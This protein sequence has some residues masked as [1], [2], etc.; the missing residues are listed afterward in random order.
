ML[1]RAQA[2]NQKLLQ[3][4]AVT[5]YTQG[6]RLIL[7]TL[8]TPG[9][10]IPQVDPAA[11]AR[12]MG[13]V[14]TTVP[15]SAAEYHNAIVSPREQDFIAELLNE[16]GGESSQQ[17]TLY[18]ITKAKVQLCFHRPDLGVK[19]LQLA[20]IHQ[21]AGQPELITFLLVQSL[22]YLALIRVQTELQAKQN[23]HHNQSGKMSGQRH[24]TEHTY[25]TNASHEPQVRGGSVG[26]DATRCAAAAV[27]SDL[28]FLTYWR[29]VQ[30]NQVQLFRF[31][32]SN[33]RDFQ[34]QYLL[35]RAEMAHTALHAYDQGFLL[36]AGDQLSEDLLAPEV[37]RAKQ[38]NRGRSDEEDIEPENQLNAMMGAKA[39]KDQVV[40]EEKKV[41]Q[42]RENML[43]AK[44]DAQQKEAMTKGVRVNIPLHTATGANPRRGP[45][46]GTPTL[47]QQ[48]LQNQQAAAGGTH[49]PNYESHTASR[50]SVE[51]RTRHARRILSRQYHM[52]TSVWLLM[53]TSALPDSFCPGDHRPHK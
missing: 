27:A 6:M 21:V 3:D 2:E 10:N 51:V 48:Q 4:Y 9:V 15:R 34:C 43:A 53:W 23:Q 44:K 5:R 50:H 14:G 33:Q 31:A 8:T 49:L 16:A 12:P 20:D 39:K 28:L 46:T 7:P 18:A 1:T 17:L 41:A 35:V 42:K 40:L 30:L 36:E 11:N 32:M 37:A 25:T 45:L 13:F 22:T 26:T 52:M 38:A 29:Q 24:P 47:L 19:T